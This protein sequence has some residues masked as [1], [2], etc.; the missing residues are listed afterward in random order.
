[1]TKKT[2][3][4]NQRSKSTRAAVGNKPRAKTATAKR[5]SSTPKASTPKTS[6][7]TTR[8]TADTKTTTKGAKTPAPAKSATPP[9]AAS[10][11]PPAKAGAKGAAAKP[12]A[13]RADAAGKP[14]AAG[15]KVAPPKA[16]GKAGARPAVDESRTPA[17]LAKAAMKNAAG[18]KKAP[19]KKS[20]YSRTQLAPL[21]RA[22]LELR[23]RMIG[24]LN[25][26]EQ[27]ALRADDPDVDVEN[28]ADHGSDAFERNMT[29]GLMEGEARTL[30]QIGDALEAMD[31]GR[32]GLCAVCGEPIPLARLEALPFAQ[33]CVPCQEAHERRL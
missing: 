17:G 18:P 28:V 27:E 19:P 25:Q 33:N 8:K 6:S 22:L 1:M 12:M 24:D 2:T 21:R 20:P 4:A 9:R 23:Q 30:R 29:L 10:A 14:A 11:T 26:M 3:K 16:A 13:G 5:T 32:Y 7:M 31:G 15:A